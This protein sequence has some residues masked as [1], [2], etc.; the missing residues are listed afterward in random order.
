MTV[1]ARRAATGFVWGVSGSDNGTACR[2]RQAFHYDS[3]NGQSWKISVEEAPGNRYFIQ[4]IAPNP[5]QTH[6]YRLD[7]QDNGAKLSKIEQ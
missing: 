1:T 3:D 5:D 4:L 6:A 7:W 2:Y